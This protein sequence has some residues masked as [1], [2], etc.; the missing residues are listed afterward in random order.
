MIPADSIVGF[1]SFSPETSTDKS[2]VIDPANTS[3]NGTQKAL[4]EMEG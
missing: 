2:G 4:F 3:F 1:L